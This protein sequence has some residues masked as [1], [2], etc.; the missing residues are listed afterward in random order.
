MLL[1]PRLLN[2]S[3]D[4]VH[5]LFR[6]VVREEMAPAGDDE[7]GGCGKPPGRCL[8]EGL[9]RQEWVTLAGDDDNGARH[10]MQ[11]LSRQRAWCQ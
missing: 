6:P 3:G 4:Q 2:G 5:D 8:S 10:L 9:T 7:G 1:V 11:H